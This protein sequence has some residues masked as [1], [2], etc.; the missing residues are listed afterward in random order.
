MVRNRDLVTGEALKTPCLESKN[1]RKTAQTSARNSDEFPLTLS[2]TCIQ[3]HQTPTRTG[4]EEALF[5]NYDKNDI[6]KKAENGCSLNSKRANPCRFGPDCPF[7]ILHF[8]FKEASQ[9]PRHWRRQLFPHLFY[10]DIS[11]VLNSIKLTSLGRG[12]E[13]PFPQEP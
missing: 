7:S 10:S 5:L 4:I 12:M 3:T 6:T 11:E 13:I 1:L 8:F 9:T 2:E